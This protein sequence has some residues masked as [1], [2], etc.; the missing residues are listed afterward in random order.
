MSTLVSKYSLLEQAKRMDPDG[1]QAQIAEI[2]NY[3][4]AMLMDAPWAVSYTR[5]N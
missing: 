1:T 4:N 5:C 2:L 3:E